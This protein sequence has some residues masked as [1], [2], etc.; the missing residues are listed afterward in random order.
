[1]DS[2]VSSAIYHK[3]S[4]PKVPVRVSERW[5]G[6]VTEL[7]DGYL[8]A[9][10]VP[11]GR[12]EPMLVGDI[13]IE[14]VDEDD[15]ALVQ[16]G[17]SFYLNVGFVPLGSGRRSRVSSIRFRRLP[18]WREDDVAFLRERA[19]KQWLAMGFDAAE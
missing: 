14:Q 10:L 4:V 16:E 8:V 12:E 9:R 7:G 17:A 19:R 1:M 3:A 18:P 13:D 6:V 2:V 11:L 5:E 15:R